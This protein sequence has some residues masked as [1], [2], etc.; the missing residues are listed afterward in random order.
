[1]NPAVQEAR[2]IAIN[3]K[4]RRERERER[5]SDDFITLLKFAEF[6]ESKVSNKRLK[7]F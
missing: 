7:C 3:E 1:M 6:L 2:N 4:T 5:E